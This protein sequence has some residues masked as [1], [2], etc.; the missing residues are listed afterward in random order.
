VRRGRTEATTRT[1]VGSVTGGGR[2]ATAGY[3]AVAHHERE[4]ENWPPTDEGASVTDGTARRSGSGRRS[5]RSSYTEPAVPQTVLRSISG[6]TETNEHWET[7]LCSCHQLQSPQPICTQLRTSV[8][9][10]FY[11][12]TWR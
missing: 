6:E 7:E 9:L 4:R 3:A 1:V 5:S 2:D 12:A 11:V 10:A 8:M